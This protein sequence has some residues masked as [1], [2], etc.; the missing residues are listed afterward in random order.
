[1]FIFLRLLL[2]HLVADFPLQVTRVY[3][4][5]TRSLRGQAVH[6]A[7]HGATFALFL[8]PY[9]CRP[10]TWVL[11]CLISLFH[12]PVDWVKIAI[13]RKWP[14]LDNVS[15]FL[16]DQFLHIL[17]LAFVFLTPLRRL[18]PCVTDSPGLF[19]RLYNDNRIV[20][21]LIVYLAATWGGAFFI[22]SL[23]K[24]IRGKT[25]LPPAE[26]WHGIAERSLYLLLPIAGG[27]WWLLALPLV[28]LR[29]LVAN[30][31]LKA[32]HPAGSIGSIGYGLV[33]LA[34]GLGG[35][36]LLRLYPC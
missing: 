22:S 3:E 17:T 9:L 27:L 19:M 20:V 4:A 15:T 6:A 18:Q 11:I 16:L 26:K 28:F 36:F 33:S 29:P 24:T 14:G 10:A 23:E 34:I 31:I 13:T 1:M 32:G 12:I 21:F 35:G 5:K 7:I 2:A 25:E 30:R 8:L